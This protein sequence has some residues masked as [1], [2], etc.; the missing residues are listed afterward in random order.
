MRTVPGVRDDEAIAVANDTEYGLSARIITRDEERG[1]A[2]AHRL[3]TGMAHINCSSVNDE[4][5]IPFG[6]AKDS[7][8]GRHGGAPGSRHGLVARRAP[9]ETAQLLRKG[10]N[11][12]LSKATR[13]EVEP[14]LVIHE[15]LPVADDRLPDQ[16]E[17][18][19]RPERA[20]VLVVDRG[21]FIAFVECS[22]HDSIVSV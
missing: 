19:G 18:N 17:R 15:E 3:A 20:E 6:G 8:L 9:R 13:P 5:W 2:I 21:S 1:L 4:P 7:G 12:G 14:F 11:C 22:Q 16:H 10:H